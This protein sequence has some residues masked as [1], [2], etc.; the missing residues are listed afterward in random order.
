M[1]EGV[2][3]NM[4]EKI[5]LFVPVYNCEIQ[6]IRVL[7]Q[8][9]QSVIKYFDEIIIVN[10]RSTDQTEQEIIRWVNHHKNFPVSVFRNDDN[11]GLG[12]S[13]KVAFGYALEKKFDYVV[14]L[15]G[16]DQGSI[17][18]ILPILDKKSYKFYDCC[19]GA[20]FMKGSELKGYSKFRTCGNYIYNKFFS[21]ICGFHVED[22]GSGLNLYSTRIL[23]SKYYMKYPD[24]LMFNYCMVMALDYYKQKVMFFPI[25]WREDDQISNVKLFQQAYS[26]LKMLFDYAL[27]HS[28]FMNKELRDSSRE[29]YT[30]KMIYSNIED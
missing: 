10:N 23:Q 9:N 12:G 2:E 1:G 19:L 3:A 17:A 4:K 21:I 15:H 24:N 5:L 11:Y 13:H 14:V 8:L 22:L 7:N 30:A 28:K 6:I 16:D 26:V 25:T 20:R 27:N 18:D 29:S